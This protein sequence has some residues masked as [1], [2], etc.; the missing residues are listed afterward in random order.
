MEEVMATNYTRL[1]QFYKQFGKYYDRQFAAFS[2][3]TGLSMRE[4][5]VLLFL[6]NNP[7][8]DTARDVA[9]YRGLAK[10]QVSQAVELLAAEGLLLRTPDSTD[11]RVIHLSIT[12]SGLPLAR[13]CQ[14]IQAACG[15]R[16]LAGLS[17]EQERQLALLLETV[18][19]N[20]S[21]LA[22]EGSV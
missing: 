17:E 14:A 18:L 8:Y 12:P 10:S 21:R 5:H 22:E 7:G 4:I 16:L 11:R 1:L 9:E 19:D 6:A 20:G 13:E 3:R 15:R 2:A